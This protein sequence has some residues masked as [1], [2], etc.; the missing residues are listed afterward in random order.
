MQSPPPPLMTQFSAAAVSCL[1]SWS[2]MSPAGLTQIA[3]TAELLSFVIVLVIALPQIDSVPPA[4][5]MTACVMLND[6][7]FEAAAAWVPQNPGVRQIAPPHSSGAGL[8]GFETQFPVAGS[9]LSVVQLSASASQCFGSP[10][11]Q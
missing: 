6:L 4:A 7:G 8:V 5:L 3:S 11:S 2:R 9:Q 10:D 1:A